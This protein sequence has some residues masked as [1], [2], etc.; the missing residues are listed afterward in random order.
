MSASSTWPID[1][2]V[3][4]N[5]VPICTEIPMIFGTGTRAVYTM[6]LPSSCD[7][8]LDSCVACTNDCRCGR[9]T[10]H[11]PCASIYDMP[12]SRIFGVSVYSP[13]FERTYPIDSSVSSSRRAVGRAR[14][15]TAA[16]S[17]TVSDRCEVEKARMT[18]SPRA[19]ASTKSRSSL[20]DAIVSDFPTHGGFPS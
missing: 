13:S 6:S 14:P 17:L 8:E 7:I 4:G 2:A 15:V 12:S 19:S 16:T 11:M 9:A 5:R 18:S 20:M 1:V 3:A 10:S